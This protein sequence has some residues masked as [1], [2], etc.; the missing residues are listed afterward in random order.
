MNKPG[1]E[2]TLPDPLKHPERHAFPIS[3]RQKIKHEDS[4]HQK[5][6]P[7]GDNVVGILENRRNVQRA[8]FFLSLLSSSRL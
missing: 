6:E 1:I 5:G 2:R 7:T 8:S 4:Q 3:P